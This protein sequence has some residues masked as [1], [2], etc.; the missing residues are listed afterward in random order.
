MWKLRPYASRMLFE[1]NILDKARVT[2][3]LFLRSD[4][5]RA[6]PP[7]GSLLTLVLIFTAASIY[8][9][10]LPSERLQVLQGQDRACVLFVW[11]KINARKKQMPESCHCVSHLCMKATPPQQQQP[12][13][14]LGRCCLDQSHIHTGSIFC[15]A[16]KEEMVA[17]HNLVL[18]QL[19][20]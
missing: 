2:S 16:R 3:R 9:S 10:A 15:W 14:P 12:L 11:K 5:S 7:G 20:W 13:L 18:Q 4:P 1:R 19:I 8:F 17:W 6:V